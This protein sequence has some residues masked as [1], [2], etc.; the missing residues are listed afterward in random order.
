MVHLSPS[1]SNLPTNPF[2]ISTVDSGDSIASE[3]KGDYLFVHGKITD[4]QGN[5]I[6]GAVI[7][8][9]ETDGFGM[10]D[11][12]V[13]IAYLRGDMIDFFQSTPTEKDQNVGV[14]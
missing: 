9:W 12:Q 4:T 5:P 6:A 14:D 7:D 13:R 8:T 1:S 11:T 3:G 2:C 10:Y